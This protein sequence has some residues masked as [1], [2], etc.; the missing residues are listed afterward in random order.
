[1]P[2]DL[3]FAWMSVLLRG[4][5]V[6]LFLPTLGARP[7]PPTMRVALCVLLATLLYGI[8]PRTAVLPGTMLGLVLATLGEIVL[9]LVMG[10]MARLIFSAVEMAGRVITQEIGLTA[11]PGIETPLPSSEPLA[12]FLSMFA[13]MLF[14]LVGGHLGALAAFA[15][16]FTIAPAGAAGFAPLAVESLVQSTA[17]L[18]EL[19]FRIA[20]PF[21]ALNFL[22]MLA[23]SVLGKA[24]PKM[25]VFVLS[26]P[27]RFIV[28]AI[29]LSGSGALI[30]RYLGPEFD[31]LPYRMLE[32]VGGG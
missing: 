29:L 25:S 16:S 7:L 8:V 13:G 12:S 6:V 3:L 28:G 15:R 17:H 24:V 23:F 27:M 11:A 1:M 22:V 4:L 20:A 9:G 2:A 32:I 19:G 21:M 18:I 14:F 26:Y 10:F 31:E 5:G 30:V